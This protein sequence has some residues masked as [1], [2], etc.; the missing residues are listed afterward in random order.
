MPDTSSTKPDFKAT[1]FFPIQAN[2]RKLSPIYNSEIAFKIWKPCMNEFA[3]ERAE[4]SGFPHNEQTRH[5]RPQGYDSS[6]WMCNYD[7]TRRKPGRRPGYFDFVC[8]R[9][10]HWLADL[11][12]FA[13]C[14]AFPDVPWRI[15]R[16][17]KHTTVW[18]GDFQMPVVF[19]LNYLAM[20]CS[21]KDCLEGAW[22]EEELRPGEPLKA[23]LFE[24]VLEQ[25][26][27]YA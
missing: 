18:N 25:E 26:D 13:A 20:R 16:G 6:D 2:W 10:C 14:S 27:H 24:D 4:D 3:T 7:E 17:K 12:L 19:D 8:H 5:N 22:G 11:N 1:Q 9:A 15:T 21:P 23:Y